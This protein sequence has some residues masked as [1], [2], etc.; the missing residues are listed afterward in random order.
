M[1]EFLVEVTHRQGSFL[2]RQEINL[3]ELETF[4]MV[5]IDR[6]W[7][8]WSHRI[9]NSRLPLGYYIFNGFCFLINR[10][11]QL[12]HLLL[13]FVF[14]YLKFIMDPILI[15][16]EKSVKHIELNSQR[17]SIFSGSHCQ[18][19]LTLFRQ[20]INGFPISVFE[21]YFLSIYEVFEELLDI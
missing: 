8:H 11:D 9:M 21:L 12:S 2:P 10:V 13:V 1:Q 19:F 17:L 4:E 5:R 6:L 15:F 18:Y 20:M 3:T 14:K 7:L 16:L